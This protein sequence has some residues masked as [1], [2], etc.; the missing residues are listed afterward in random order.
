M[1]WHTGPAPD[2][3]APPAA[4]ACTTAISFGPGIRSQTIVP[5]ITHAWVFTVS[6]HFLRKRRPAGTSKRSGAEMLHPNPSMH[7]HADRGNDLYPTPAP[8]MRA[9][10]GVPVRSF[11]CT[12]PN[13]WGYPAKDRAGRLDQVEEPHLGRLISKLTERRTLPEQKLK[14]AE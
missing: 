9:R 3:S 2:R 10:D 14:A 8:A 13:T 12:T 6:A 1:G 11:V 4:A 7:A 5:S